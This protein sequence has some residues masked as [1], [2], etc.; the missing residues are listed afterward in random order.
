MDRLA[1]RGAWPAESADRPGRRGVGPCLGSG[2]GPRL[3]SAAEAGDPGRVAAVR[4]RRPARPGRGGLGPRAGP[5]HEPVGRRGHAS[6]SSTSIRATRSQDQDRAILSKTLEVLRLS[7]DEAMDTQGRRMTVSAVRVAGRAASFEF[8]PNIDTIMI[9]P[10]GHAGRAG[11]VGRRPRSTSRSTCPTTGAAGGTIAG[12]RT[13]STGIRSSPTTTTGA[14]SGPRSSPGTSPGTR[15]R[16]ITRSAS[17][18]P[19]TR[20]SPRR[21]G[22]PADGP[23]GPG[24]QLVTIVASPSRDFA[25]VCSD[26][27]EVLERPVGAT[28]VRVVA[29]PRARGQRRADPGAS[30]PRSSR[31]TSAGS[32]RTT[33]TSSRSPRRS[34]AGTA[35]SARAWSCSTT[36]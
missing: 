18:C 27:F 3:G 20:S 12:S 5:V 32:A 16:A 4:H 23:R 11:G 17:T 34:S 9:V 36:G 29:L 8:D 21:A 30:P 19:R 13:C 26:R 28:L 14:G 10:L 35:T 15:R 31:S 6:W 22:S 7:P 24:R 1:D 2:A 33:T 25:L